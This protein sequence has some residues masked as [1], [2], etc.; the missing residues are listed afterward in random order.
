MVYNI[1]KRIEDLEKIVKVKKVINNEVEEKQYN[2]KIGRA[3]V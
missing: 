1:K 2:D 3:H